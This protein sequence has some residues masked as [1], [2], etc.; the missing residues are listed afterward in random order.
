M[1]LE[2]GAAG[3][4]CAIEL[5]ADE[6]C[7]DAACGANCPVTDDASFQLYLACIQ[8]ANAGGCSF[9]ASQSNRCTAAESDGGASICF[10]SQSFQDLYLAIAPLFCG[11]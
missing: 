5:Q 10:R 11:P 7:A 8:Q 6:A 9:Y 4:V 3:H 2:D 1:E